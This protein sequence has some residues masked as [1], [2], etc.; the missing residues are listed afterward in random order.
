MGWPDPASWWALE[1][2]RMKLCAVRSIGHATSIA[3]R[4]GL[5]VV[6]TC[7]SPRRSI[8]HANEVIVRFLGQVRS[9]ACGSCPWTMFNVGMMEP[10]GPLVRCRG[11]PGIASPLHPRPAQ[12]RR[13]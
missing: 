1:F 3:T 9:E 11:A 13:G 6:A 5:L 2:G 8:C 10:L 12:P 4:C 7:Q